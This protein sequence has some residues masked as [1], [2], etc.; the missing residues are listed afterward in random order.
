MALTY[1]RP[2]A[3]V[4]LNEYKAVFISHGLSSD[5]RVDGLEIEPLVYILYISKSPLSA[6]V[7]YI[8]SS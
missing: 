7:S 4:W 6:A 1:N 2:P 5:I 8:W 3:S